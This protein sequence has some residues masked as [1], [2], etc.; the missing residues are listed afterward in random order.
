MQ[1]DLRRWHDEM[2]AGEKDRARITDA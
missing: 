2:L 1:A